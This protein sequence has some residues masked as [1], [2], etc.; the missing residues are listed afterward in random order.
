MTE[1]LVGDEEGPV[2]ARGRAGRAVRGRRRARSPAS[3]SSTRCATRAPGR[4]L[5]SV[6]SPFYGPKLWY[7]DDPA[8]EWEQAEGVALP[9]GGDAALERIWVDR[10]RRG[11][12]HGLRGRRPGRAVRE[13]RRRRDAGSSTAGCGSSPA[14]TQLAAGRA[15]GCACTRSSTW[16]GEPDRLALG[17][18]AAGVWLTDDGGAT[19]RQRQRGHRARATCPRSRPRTRSRSACTASSAR[20]RGRERLFMQ[21]HGGVYRSDDAGETWTDIADGLPSDFGFPLAIDPADPDSAYVIPLV[22]D[23]DRVTPEGRVRVYETRDAGATWTPRGDGLPGRDAYL[24][25]LREAFASRGEGEALELYFGATSGDVFGS[26]DAGRELVRGGDAP[27]ARPGGLGDRLAVAVSCGGRAARPRRS[28]RRQAASGPR[29]G[30]P[31]RRRGRAG[32]AGRVPR[33]GS[34]PP[35]PSSRISTRR[36]SASTGDVHG[37][38]LGLRVLGHVGERL[39]RDEVGG[40]LDGAAASWRPGTPLIRTGTGARVGER[41]QRR[42]EAAV[43]EERRV[44]AAREVA[45][46]LHRELGLLARLGDQARGRAAGS[47][48]QARLGEA[49]R[50]GDGDQPL[51]GAV[52]QV[53][54]D[55]PALLVGG[56]DDALAGAAQVVDALAQRARPPQLGGLAREADA[57]L[58]PRAVGDLRPRGPGIDRA[59]ARAWGPGSAQDLGQRRDRAPVAAHA[60]P[61]AQELAP[62]VGAARHDVGPVVEGHAQG[63]VGVAARPGAAD[64]PA[65]SSTTCHGS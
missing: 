8:G 16:P 28:C 41:L 47:L 2:R 61:P 49:E 48:C 24:T 17:I 25:V 37:G 26:G 58:G 45:Q 62:R 12:R 10:R 59:G 44:D 46:L 19:W 20:R 29:T 3:R 21:F 35:T 65:G 53:A 31:A 60:Q 14:A 51:L 13:P 56:G 6:T 1:L 11:R 9:E 39:G 30:R 18:S 43:A 42:A 22:A 54:L 36:R 38:R 32:R 63:D 5:A 57:R 64:E 4:V 55:A 23:I 52:V 27:A 15:A 40:G 34:A 7:A 33:A 50:E